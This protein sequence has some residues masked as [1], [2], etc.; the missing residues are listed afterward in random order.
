MDFN[1]EEILFFPFKQ[2]DWKKPF[3]G[4]FLPYFIIFGVSSLIWL[5]LQFAPIFM[6][7]SPD[8]VL[9][10]FVIFGGITGLLF[11][12]LI[13][14]SFYLLG[15][16]FKLYDYVRKDQEELPQH[17]DIWKTFVYGL[18]VFIVNMLYIL[19]VMIIFSAFFVVL[20]A[21]GILLSVNNELSTFGSFFVIG[22]SM[23]FMVAFILMC[24]LFNF[25]VICA[26]YEFL[27]T[28]SI[29]AALNYKKVWGYV[30]LVWQDILV[31]FLIYMAIAMIVGFCLGFI[32][33][34]LVYTYYIFLM[35]K[36]FG[37][38]FK[39]LDKLAPK[40]N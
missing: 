6:S 34:P 21:G 10:L 9:P 33:Q 23:I 7:E 13:P 36:I 27:R 3:L 40:V 30:K 4:I 8:I 29:I 5:P 16:Q 15:Y 1:F 2:K 20:A 22:G 25:I 14:F 35:T 26:D 28:G 37:T 31:G 12:F 32:I 18:K 19:P 11:L 17:T 39:K 38:V 24:V